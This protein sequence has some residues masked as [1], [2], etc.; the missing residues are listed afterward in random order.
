MYK[1]IKLLLFIVII[2]IVVD[3]W[4]ASFLSRIAHPFGWL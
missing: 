1:I 3:F 2:M 4:S